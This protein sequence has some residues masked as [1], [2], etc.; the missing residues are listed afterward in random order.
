MVLRRNGHQ[1]LVLRRQR[2]RQRQLA[3]GLAALPAIG[4]ADG[5]RGLAGADGDHDAIL[6]AR[7]RLDHLANLR[8]LLPV[9]V[10]D[11]LDLRRNVA[12]HVAQDVRRGAEDV[13]AFLPDDGRGIRGQALSE[14]AGVVRKLDP[15]DG[16]G[17]CRRG[18]L[19]APLLRLRRLASGAWPM[20]RE[21]RRHRAPTWEAFVLPV[22][23]HGAFH[24]TKV[25]RRRPR[26]LTVAGP[27]SAALAA[28]TFCPF[29]AGA[30]GAGLAAGLKGLRL[31]V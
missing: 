25:P 28:G 16:G 3:C 18:L 8:V 12:D 19:A 17:R 15:M 6:L 24:E 27:R 5:P 29:G 30:L 2:E 9:G 20:R 10:V 7:S 22:A 11:H 26:A 1:V 31:L 4:D 23:L 14:Q 21:H 13:V